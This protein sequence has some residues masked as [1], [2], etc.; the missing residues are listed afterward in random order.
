[1]VNTKGG[2]GQGQGRK[3]DWGKKPESRIGV[4][5]E[6]V[7]QKKHIVEIWTVLQQCGL[8][9]RDLARLLKNHGIDLIRQNSDN[10]S[11]PPSNFYRIYSTPV[12][13]SFGLTSS[14]DAEAGGYEESHLESILSIQSPERT[15]FLQ[16]IGDSMIDDGISEG[17][18]L[19]VETSDTTASKS[20]LEP[21]T[22][23]AVI[24]LVDGTDL[25][26]KRFRRSNE[27]E[28]L[29]PRNRKNQN[30]QPIQ[31]SSRDPGWTGGHEVEIFGIVRKIVLD[32]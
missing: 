11:L 16:V 2:S 30:F 5:F 29:E 17:A 7:P 25:T 24:A 28:F 6:V 12:A 20:W 18:I 32:P 1:M 19:T 8:E 13:A 23:D 4:P 22:G 31:I 21:Q 27:G 9:F 14:F 15:I 3:P 26:V 10:S